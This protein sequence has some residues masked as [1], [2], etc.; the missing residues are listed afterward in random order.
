MNNKNRLSVLVLLVTVLS[1]CS[2]EAPE[3]AGVEPAA[4]PALSSL[5]QG[6]ALIDREGIEAHLNFLADD[7]RM[8]RFPGTP[9]YEESAAYVADRFAEIGLEPGWR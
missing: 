1:A 8:G 7:A 3:Q 9:G 5:E 4:A 2:R 6:L